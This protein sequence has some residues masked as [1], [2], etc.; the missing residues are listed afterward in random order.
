MNRQPPG[1]TNCGC[2]DEDCPSHNACRGCGAE[3][4]RG[5][6][7]FCGALECGGPVLLDSPLEGDE[8]PHDAITWTGS[9]GHGRY[10]HD[11][12]GQWWIDDICADLTGPYPDEG[13]AREAAEG[14]AMVSRIASTFSEPP[15]DSPEGRPREDYGAGQIEALVRA[16]VPRGQTAATYHVL[17]CAA[18]GA[19]DITAVRDDGLLHPNDVLATLCKAIDAATNTT[20]IYQRLADLGIT[21][22]QASAGVRAARGERE[23]GV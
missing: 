8:P 13:Q 12:H 6:Q 20:S 2:T 19:V 4:P 11:A 15:S 7:R 18:R 16:V 21:P 14:A 3:I 9:I 17:A 23:C 1:V 5:A 10:G 22:A